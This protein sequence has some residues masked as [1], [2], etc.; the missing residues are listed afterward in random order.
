[1]LMSFASQVL[2]SKSKTTLSPEVD[3][4]EEEVLDGLLEAFLGVLA[5]PLY[6]SS[7]DLFL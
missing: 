6:F 5:G 4:Q 3:P 7:D 1:M 2:H